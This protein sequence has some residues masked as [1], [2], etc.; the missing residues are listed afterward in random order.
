M[1]A[2]NPRMGAETATDGQHL[3]TGFLGTPWL[4]PAA[5]PR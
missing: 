2:E 1:A 4:L 5:L 3:K